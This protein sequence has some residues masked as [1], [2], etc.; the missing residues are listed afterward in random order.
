[1]NKD[2]AKIYFFKFFDDFVLIYPFYTLMFAEHSTTPVQIG[3][4]LSIWSIVTLV[5]EVPSGVAADKYSRRHILFFAQIIRATGYLVWILSPTFW[6]FLTGFVLWGIKSALTSG[7][8]QAL[9]YDLLKN[10]G[11]ELEYAKIMGRAKA[12][13]YL[14]IFSSSGGAALAIHFGY[15][16]VLIL[17]IISVL[18]S[19]LAIFFVSADTKYNST[20]ELDYLLIIKKGFSFVLQDKHIFIFVFL[21][22]IIIA[23]GGAIDEFFSMFANLTNVSKSTIAIFIGGI[24]VTQAIGSL[25]ATKC[26]KLPNFF[27]CAMLIVSGLLFYT[28]ST[29]LNLTSLFL[30]VIF[31]IIQGLGSIIIETRLQHI[32]PSNIRATISSVQ[33]FIVELVAIFV[34]MGL[35]LLADMVELPTAFQIF[36]LLLV[37]FA[38]LYH[39]SELFKQSDT[40]ASK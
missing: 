3:I 28:A 40:V 8:Y 30:L 24:S 39:L 10:Q 18:L 1:M 20:N 9:L 15:T 14:A 29:I 31:S 25:F 23:L 11:K 16:F 22:S 4:L 27:F 37:G 7:T 13:S 35:G 5:L 33:G 38:C 32:I 6:G 34:Y 2:L 21:G 19:G 12:L 36:G 26:E 17:S